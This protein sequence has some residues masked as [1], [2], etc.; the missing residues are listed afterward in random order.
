MGTR[1]IA[2]CQQQGIRIIQLDNSLKI[3]GSFRRA[4]Q[5]ALQE[6][7]VAFVTL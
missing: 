2:Q 7:F 4:R 1:N 3:G 5:F 6:Q